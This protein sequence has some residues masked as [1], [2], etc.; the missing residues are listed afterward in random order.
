MNRVLALPKMET[1]QGLLHTTMLNL[2]SHATSFR[3]LSVKA[4]RERI[5][6]IG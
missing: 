1:H 4:I 3:V 5:V 6:P 2:L